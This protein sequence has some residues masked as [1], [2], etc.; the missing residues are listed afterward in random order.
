MPKCLSAC[1]IGDAHPFSM[2]LKTN[3]TESLLWWL[4]ALLIIGAFVFSLLKPSLH[5]LLFENRPN[6]KGIKTSPEKI[7]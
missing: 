1:A 2:K 4:F 3:R 6:W 7:R 5:R